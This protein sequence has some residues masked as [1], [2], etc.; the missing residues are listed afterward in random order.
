MKTI[1]LILD[2]ASVFLCAVTV[3]FILLMPE[4]AQFEGV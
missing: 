2:I 4:A 1:D 3:I